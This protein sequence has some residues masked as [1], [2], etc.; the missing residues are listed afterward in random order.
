MCNDTNDVLNEKRTM[1]SG[2]YDVIETA[3]QDTKQPEMVL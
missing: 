3:V 1:I 2:Y